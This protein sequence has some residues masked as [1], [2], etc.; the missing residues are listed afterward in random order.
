MRIGAA[1]LSL[2]LA[3]VGGAPAAPPPDALLPVEQYTSQK[4][5]TL[6]L[7][8]AQDLRTL[9]LGIYHCI[10]WVE[11]QPY[12]IGFFKPRHLPGADDRYLSLRI[13]IEQDPSPV[14]A[15]MPIEGRASA[16]FSRYAGPMLRRMTR[17]PALLGDTDVDGFT[18]ILEWLKQETRRAGARPVHETI[19]VFVD[20]PTT[21]AYL[22]T[23]LAG[24]ELADRSQVFGWDGERPLGRLRL[25]AYDDDFVDTY[26]LPNYTVEPGVTCP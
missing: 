19:A 26:K 10:P 5:R 17:N 11:T 2:L 6:A 24:R 3:V 18:V 14:F 8:Y 15:G 9:Q 12:S 22:S 25:S 20:K 1:T 23:Q 4:A 7:R 21:A 13:F 16:M